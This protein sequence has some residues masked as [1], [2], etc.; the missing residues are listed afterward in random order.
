MVLFVNN[1]AYLSV[2]ANVSVSCELTI[3]WKARDCVITCV[4]SEDVS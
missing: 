3:G 2:S 1:D 4:K